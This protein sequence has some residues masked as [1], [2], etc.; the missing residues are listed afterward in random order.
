MA[1]YITFILSS[2]AWYFLHGVELYINGSMMKGF[3][4]THLPG[5]VEE[6]GWFTPGGADR[7]KAFIQRACMWDN[8]TQ[9][10]KP[11]AWSDDHQ[12]LYDSISGFGV[13]VW[14]WVKNVGIPF[15]P[16]LLMWFLSR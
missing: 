7:R 14:V 1:V 9:S 10:Y 2:S 5:A 11:F 15:G 12:R 4:R 3:W 6:I 13:G 8:A 16:P